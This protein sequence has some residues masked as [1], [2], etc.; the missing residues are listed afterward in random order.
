MRF[1]VEG[2]AVGFDGRAIQSGL[3]FA[4]SA[5]ER[6]AIT[7]PSGCGK[8]TLLRTLAMLDAPI[9]GRVTLDGKTPADHEVPRWRRRVLYAAQRAAF[10]GGDVL[11]ELERPFAY[12]SAERAFDRDAAV[13]GLARV[14]LEAKT[15]AAV[16]ELSE[17]ERQRVALVRAALLEPH[18]LLLDEPTSAL[19]TTTAERVEHWLVERPFAIVI[20]THDE[21]QRDR[22]CTEA[23]ELE[24]IDG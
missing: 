8:T 17:G 7:G 18:V 10:F 22:L 13:D 11:E 2:L 14:G 5:G 4:L 20:V 15:D 19:D 3:S 6:L 23:L 12:R 1:S 24:A 9:E 16:D 21:A